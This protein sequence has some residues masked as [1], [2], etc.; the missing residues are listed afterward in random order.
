MSEGGSDRFDL[1]NCSECGGRT[2]AADADAIV[3]PECGAVYY[4]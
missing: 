1:D 4:P 2:K 3:C